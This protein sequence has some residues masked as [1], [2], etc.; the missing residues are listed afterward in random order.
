VLAALGYAAGDGVLEVVSVFV[1]AGTESDDFAAFPPD[2][3]RE[4]VR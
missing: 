1:F 4:S 2:S 3:D